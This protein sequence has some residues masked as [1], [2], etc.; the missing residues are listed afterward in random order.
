MNSPCISNIVPT[1]HSGDRSLELSCAARVGSG[2]QSIITKLTS[3]LDQVHPNPLT[4]FSSLNEFPTEPEL[5][6]PDIFGP[7]A[8]SQ[9]KG[10]KLPVWILIMAT[11]KLPISLSFSLRTRGI[12]SRSKVGRPDDPRCAH[13]MDK[14]IALPD[15]QTCY[16]LFFLFLEPSGTSLFKFYNSDFNTF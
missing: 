14:R 4:H 1:S 9:P 5:T 7:Q 16:R 6:F 10:K 11:R 12:S 3:G 8:Y 2:S 15:R 13:R